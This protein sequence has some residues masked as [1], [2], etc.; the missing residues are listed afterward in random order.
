MHNASDQAAVGTLRG[1]FP[2]RLI[3]RIFGMMIRL[4]SLRIHAVLDF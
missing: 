3:M 4:R 2:S 1:S